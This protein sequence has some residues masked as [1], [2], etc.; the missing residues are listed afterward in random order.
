MAEQDP[1]E[2]PVTTTPE[3]KAEPAVMPTAPANMPKKNHMKVNIWFILIVLVLAA[4]VGG[5]VLYT[6][7]QNVSVYDGLT[8]GVIVAKHPKKVVAKTTSAPAPAPTPAAA[9]TDQNIV[10]I[11]ELGIQ[12]TVP[13]SLKD[14]AYRTRTTNSTSLTADFS[15][16]TLIGKDA[17]CGDDGTSETPPLGALSK[18]SGQYPTNPTIEN[19]NGSLV[20]QFSTYYIGYSSPQAV[21]SNDDAVNKLAGDDLTAFKSALSSMTE[22]K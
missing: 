20:K 21:C 4:L 14:L 3:V 17:N 11:T 1:T 16:Q 2:Q 15:T 12:I 6:Q 18:T 22:I 13:D 7:H 19:T 8:N 9:A 10:K 5:Y